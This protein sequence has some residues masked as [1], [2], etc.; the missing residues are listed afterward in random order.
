MNGTPVATCLCRS[1]RAHNA[2][3]IH[4]AHATSHLGGTHAGLYRRTAPPGPPPLLPWPWDGHQTPPSANLRC[5]A[6]H[7]HF[8]FHHAQV[9]TE[10]IP[11]T[12]DCFLVDSRVVFVGYGPSNV[13]QMLRLHYGLQDTFRARPACSHRHG[14]HGGGKRHLDDHRSARGGKGARCTSWCPSRHRRMRRRNTR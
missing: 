14:Q 7:R 8:V 3:T 13:R 5:C 6:G 10:A 12:R 11:T 1:T 4:V 2:Y 9:D